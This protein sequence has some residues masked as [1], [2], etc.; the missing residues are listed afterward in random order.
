[1]NAMLRLLV[2]LD[3]RWIFLAM[4]ISVLV[5]ILLDWRFDEI[6]TAPVER[7]FQKIESLPPGSKILMPYDFDAS[8]APELRP[9]ATAWLW[10]A[11]R[12]GHKLYVMTLWATGDGYIPEVVRE[13]LVDSGDFKNFK[14]GEDYVN[15]G[16]R[17][18]NEVVIRTMSTDLAAAFS[19][20]KQGTA[21]TQIPMMRGI[22]SLRD[23]ALI[24]NASA[25][26]PG[27]KEWVQY[28]AT[29]LSIPLV[30]G[31][32]GVQAAQMFPYYPDQILGLLA[33]IKGAAEYEALLKEKYPEYG[34]KDGKPR[35]AFLKGISTM[36][37]QLIAH[38]LIL[39]L[40]VLGNI[41]LFMQ[42]RTR[43][44]TR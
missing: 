22:N 21:T 6:P 11:A 16:Y 34:E 42:R 14:Y 29:P 26:Y 1:M 39:L 44:G 13:V 31:N 43:E 25:G 15:L 28:A 19:V 23:F 35:K 32:T 30:A 2:R 36:G 17:A 38:C 7:A 10:H 8:S 33:A 3:R 20:D 41:I 5:P 37:P 9:M 4:G 40:I 12:K 18:G 24:V 27:T